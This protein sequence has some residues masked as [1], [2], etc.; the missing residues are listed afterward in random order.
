MTT[1]LKQVLGFLLLLVAMMS[2]QSTW[3]A[4]SFEDNCKISKQPTADNPDIEIK[5]IFYD[6]NGNDS[7]F[8]HDITWVPK[9]TGA[10]TWIDAKGPAIYVDNY[11]IGSVDDVL[12]WPGGGGNETGVKSFC[13]YNGWVP[14]EYTKSYNDV[15]YKIKFWD[16]R[17][18]F[19]AA[20]NATGRYEITMCV[21]LSRLE[22]GSA[23]SVRIHGYWK[24]N[25]KGT[26]EVNHT[27]TANAV[28]APW[29]SGEP[30]AAMTSLNKATVSGS[31]DSKYATTVGVLKGEP[32][33]SPGV[34]KARSDLT[35]G[36]QYYENKTN[37][38]LV[39][40]YNRTDAQQTET[41]TAAVEYQVTRNA[42]GLGD[43]IFWKWYEI[44]VPGFVNPKDVKAKANVWTKS[45]T[46]TWNKETSGNRSQ[47]GTWSV[48]RITTNTNT[49]KTSTT[50]LKSGLGYNEQL[51]CVDDS[52]H[53]TMPDWDTDKTNKTYKVV[54][55]PDG[56]PNNTIYNSLSATSSAVQLKRDWE[57]SLQGELVD[58]DKIHLTWT[59]SRIEDAATKNYNL[60][61]E[62]R[63]AGAN[64]NTFQLIKNIPVTTPGTVD[65]EYTDAD[66]LANHNYVYRLSIYVLEENHVVTTPSIGTAGSKLLAFEA[67]RG[68]YNNVVKLNWKVKQVGINETSFLVYRRPLGT[69]GDRG[70]VQIYTTSGTGSNYSYDDETVLPGTFNQYKLVI[71]DNLD[72]FKLADGFTYN[73]GVVGGRITYGTGTA[74]E[75]AKVTL[76]QQNGDGDLATASM[77]SL[78]FADPGAGFTY[79]TDTVEIH[80]LFS[81][82]FSTQMWVRP[83]SEGMPAPASGG[84]NFFVLDVPWI[85]S[86]YL[87][88]ENGEDTYQVCPYVQNYFYTGIKIPADQWSHITVSYSRQDDSLKVVVAMP[89]GTIRRAIK[90]QTFE[91][92]EN[93]WKADKIYIA[94]NTSNTS[95]YFRGYMDEFRLFSK[96]LTDKEISRNYNH[97]LAGSEEGLAIYYPFDEGLPSQKIVYDYSKTNG[98]ANGRHGTNDKVP[99]YS[100]NVEVPSEDQ[101]SMMTYTD[102]NGNYTIRGV[103]FQGE[104]TAYSVI[105]S[106]GIH[107]FSPSSQSRFVSSSSLIHSGVDFEDISSFPVSGK[108]FY[109]GT[110]YPVQGCNFYVDGTIC[111]KDGKMA[112]SDEEGE[113]TISVPIGNHYIEV[114]KSGHVFA[115]GRYPADPDGVGTRLTFDGKITGLEFRDTTLV[116]FTGHVVGGNIEGDKPVGFGLSKN[117]LGVTEIIL[118]PVA[119]KYRMNVVK[120]QSEGVV[121]YDTNTNTVPVASATSAINSISWRGKD[122]ADCRKFFIHTDSITGE[123]SALMPPIEYKLE[124]MKLFRG[125]H[126]SVGNSQVIDLSNP[127]LVLND[128]LYNAEGTDYELYEYNTCL[129]QTYHIDPSFIVEQDGRKD[130]SFGIGKYVFKDA[131]GEV[132]IDDIYSVGDDGTVTYKYG[133]PLF[134]QNDPYIFLLKGFEEYVNADNGEVDRVPLSG[135]EVTIDNALSEEQAV[136]LNDGTDDDGNPVS[137]GEVADGKANKLKLD[138]Q[139]EAIYR[140]MAGLPNVAAPYTRTIS[141]SYDING[142]G[143][144]WSGNG[145]SG[146]ILGDLPTGNNFVTSGPDKLM[147]ILRNPPGTGSSAEWSSGTVASTST[148]GGNT[149]SEEFEAGVTLHTGWKS[150]SL[151]GVVTGTAQAGVIDIVDSDHDVTLHA[152]AQSEGEN[153][154]TIESSISISTAVATSEEPDYVGADGDVFIGRATNIIFGNARNVGFH[155]DGDGFVLDLQ[156]VYTSGVKF[157]TIFN[158][159][160]GYIENTLFPNLEMMRNTMLTRDAEPPVTEEFIQSFRNTT[161]HAVYL[162][163]LS[164]DDPDFG[165]NGTYVGFSPKNA[166]TGADST[167]IDFE[168]VCTDSIRWIN[169]QIDNWKGYLGMNEAEKVKAYQNRDNRSIVRDY[170]NYSFN[171]G[172]SITHSIEKEEATT[173]SYDWTVSAGV[174]IEWEHGTHINSLGIDIQVHDQTM[175]GRHGTEETSEGTASSFSY[176]LAEEGSDALTVDVYEYGAFSPIFRTRGGQTSNPYEG[177]VRT[178]YYEEYGTHPVIMDATMQIEVPTIGVDV[179]IVND[180]PSG[181]AANYTLR[182]GNESEIGEDVAYK[183]YVL[184]ET[185]PDGAQL[186]IDGSVLTEEGRMIKVPGGQTVTKTLQLRQTNTSILDYENIVIVFASESQPEDIYSDVEISAHFTPSSSPVTLALSN[187]T[188]NTETGTDLVLT[189]K[190]FDRNYRDLKAFRLQYKTPGSTSWTLLNKGEYVLDAANKTQN[191][192]MLPDAGASVDYIFPMASFSDGN[193]LFRAVSVATHGNGEVYRYSEELPLIKDMMRP[194]PLG[195]PEPSDGV[196]DI[197]DDLSVT[198]NETILRGMLTKEANF[199][200][201]GVLN[202]AEVAHE[203]ALAMS[204]TETAAQTE[205]AINL[206]NKDFSIDAWVYISGS[207]T[208]LTHGQ[209]VQKL[210]VGTD[211]AGKLVVTIAGNTYTS[212]E[213]VPTDKW[214]FLTMN[215][216]ADGKLSADVATADEM[217]EL[218]KG[219]D[220]TTYQGNGPLAV[221][222]GMTGAIHELLLWDEAHDLTT[223]LLNRSK[224]KAPSTRHLIGYWKMNEGEGKEIRDYSRNRH[225]TMPDE[226]WYINN[227]NKAV[228]LDGQ[229]YVSIN[230]SML[231]T[232]TAD[233]Y[234]LEFWMRGDEQTGEAQ[235][236]QMGDVALWLN[237]EGKLQLTGKNAYNPAEATTYATSGSSLTDNAWHHVALNVLRQGAAAVYVDGK[238][239]LTTNA[240]NV[241]NIVTNKLIVGARRTTVSAEDALFSFDRAFTG[242]VD[243]IRVWNATINGDQLSKNR[244]V[245]FTGNESGLVAYYPFETKTLDDYNQVV[246]LG[247]DKDLTG[248]GL[249][250]QLSTFD[251]QASALDYT[252]EAPALRTKPVETNVN[253][254]F[255]A[256]NE[257]IVIELDE[258]P[259]SIEG[260]TLNFTVRDVRDENGNY[261]VPAIWSAFVNRNELV[262]EED[263]LSVE[264]QVKDESSFTATIVNKGGQQQ[265]W[266][267]S[268]MPSWLTV[269]DEYGTTPPRGT[270]DVTFHISPAT[271]IGKYEE[272]VYLESNNGIETPL[273]I[274]VKVTG[275]I[276]DWAVNPGDFENSMNVI[277]RVDI[278]G[279]PMDDEDDIV[280]A[281][282]GEECRGIAHPS[283]KERYDCNFVTMDIY[284]NDEKNQE[285]TFR[286]YDASTGALYPVVTPDRTITFTPLALIGKYEEPVVLTVADLIEQQTELK[287][288]WNWLSLYVAPD[289]MTVP[290]VFNSISDAVMNVKSQGDGWK[291]Y[292]E[293]SWSGDLQSMT[294]EQMYAIQMSAD[295][296]LRIVGHRV[297]PA[298]TVITL[299]PGWNWIGYYGRQVS[300]VSDALAGMEPEDGDVLKGRRGVSYFDTYEWSGSLVMME[301]GLGYMLKS[302]TDYNRLFSY[303]A[304][305]VSS[306][307]GLRRAA[308]SNA[309]GMSI[310]ETSTFTP[311]NFRL[312]ANNAMMSVQ[313]KESGKILAHT[314]LGVFAGDECRATA[315]TNEDG[316]AFLTIPGDD[317][318]TLTF[319]VVVNDETVEAPQSVDYEVDGVYGSPKYP[320]VIDLNDQTGIW[321]VAGTTASPVYN[322]AG[323]RLNKAQ[324]GINIMKDRKLLI[325]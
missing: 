45:V 223:A 304:S 267:L 64:D 268:G 70:W 254:T 135:S 95:Q 178:T 231:P 82:D 74:V 277:G 197:G 5:M 86:V 29:G 107:E 4:I 66:L 114:A 160:Q 136:W 301:P 259:S 94:R 48:Y 6:S 206:S 170:T 128:T 188:M 200:I 225:M 85:L 158:Y 306:P 93:A 291:T 192:Q 239:C 169:N 131:A 195:T 30:T 263:V 33:E 84:K 322:V 14:N 182:L 222:K 155:R 269:S 251:S 196:L 133:G 181:M 120:H 186:T 245:R 191:N 285:V 230:A 124:S 255:T 34:Y 302:V 62:R 47:A 40:N 240:T 165:K 125:D 274:N 318:T 242:E 68:S 111:S 323:Q 56:S 108:V 238:R 89:D 97:P 284:G 243:E 204:N 10:D 161:D 22:V 143:Y 144:D 132:T 17:R 219:M 71:A 140:W 9:G 19:D 187:S 249:S 58:D 15:S 46:V 129:K 172:A 194:R 279:L 286:A 152:V 101:L 310:D 80:S 51:Q 151:K 156:N 316:I 211:D 35:G 98:I 198:F 226:T 119:E 305:T 266:I 55:V 134:I 139:G 39:V 147:M 163:T 141:M 90:Y 54:F 228:S 59:H 220:V 75:G 102:I 325:K 167:S 293:G 289:D 25:N 42:S 21:Y 159:T 296:M 113:F 87:R 115:N 153:S 290:S 280:A 288:G 91:W 123:F 49:N 209:G 321:G 201:T 105:P 237:G 53:G 122:N 36:N 287:T 166:K 50:L 149:W 212:E 232:T 278:E 12:S 203:T 100:S 309:E 83:D 150:I 121:S 23:H 8:T 184:N 38:E 224:T 104:G 11:Y 162:T 78:K 106:L 61:L 205:A 202:G 179:P 177:E 142:L 314:E 250:A 236:L 43:V 171:S 217:V 92:T 272:T 248:S 265:T 2:G 221:G 253:Y 252:D 297:N 3:A 168:K 216:G 28:P 185:N 65:G 73:T 110:D 246:T 7:Y 96:A 148:M 207:G 298:S 127:N 175:G 77:S 270:T 244:K 116:N 79:S 317:V 18:V 193:Y 210:A 103:S 233:D 72:E 57:I 262:W 319:K 67:T 295:R 311:V 118:T 183:L 1:R 76:K 276:P 24:T 117:N 26:H 234:A 214:A 256:S 126:R 215:V 137:A 294:N 109:S 16:P 99:A 63:E 69:E 273:T 145:M 112:E 20:G 174:L 324:K 303:P 189:F 315:F 27:M 213:A 235:L 146:I 154:T 261:S 218:F 13:D 241:G 292:E 281:F 81:G 88:R 307:Y 190:D 180:I 199:L 32:C 299:E 60:K 271:P 283:Y 257:K 258:D 31:L 260:C 130:G 157:G 300:S 52:L 312:Y 138:A 264:Q 176:T 308:K 282:I 173:S 37:Y 320:L 247:Y 208:L 229:H 44:D 227:V 164:P 275:P 313:L 41:T